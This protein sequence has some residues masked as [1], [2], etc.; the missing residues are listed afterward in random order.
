M[1]ELY[2]YISNGAAAA[3]KVRAESLGRVNKCLDAQRIAAKRG[4]PCAAPLTDAEALDGGVVVSAEEWRPGGTMQTGDDVDA[5]R[6]SAVV[7]AELMAI[8]EG[9]LGDG[10][11]PPPPWVHWNPPGGGLWPP[12]APV[13]RMDQRLVPTPIQDCARRVS[14]RLRQAALPYVLGHGDWEAQNLRWKDGR[15]WAVHDWDSLVFLPEAAIVGAA[16]GAFAS[17]ETPTLV[18]LESSGAFIDSYEST[19]GR[20]F[21]ASEREVAWAA[22]LW[23]ALHNARGEHLFGSPLTAAAAVAEQAEQR[24]KLAAA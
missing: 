19:R 1:S 14:A 15:P 9:Q 8:L 12:N 2:R 5:A 13:D 16:S 7:L 4:F 3:I 22:S 23:P 20:R 21:A 6:R 18:P 11:G 17:A 10:M 24:L